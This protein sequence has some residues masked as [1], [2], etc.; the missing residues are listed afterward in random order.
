MNNENIVKVSAVSNN[1]E[2]S[3]STP[4]L[5]EIISVTNNRA[6]YFAEQALKFRNESKIFRDETKSY[7]DNATGATLEYVNEVKDLL[8]SKIETVESRVLNLDSIVETKQ[9]SGNYALSEDIP[10]CVSA[11]ENDLNYVDKTQL[12]TSI[13]QSL[14]SRVKLDGS[15]ATFPYVTQFYING[16]S[17]YRIW[18]NG[19]KE[20]GGIA[21]IGQFTTNITVTV[22][23][24]V[25]FNTTN[26]STF[27]QIINGGNNWALVQGSSITNKKVNSFNIALYVSN[28]GTIA[29]H[30]RQWYACGY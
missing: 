16:A 27:S 30:S 17:W 14:E 2:L 29:A 23:L 26:Y 22:T 7:L 11:L 9:D 8:N 15:N 25:K 12:E 18:S 19:W 20:Q 21:S 4:S 6:Q 24:L 1:K 13:S 3:I 28:E 5:K 10:T